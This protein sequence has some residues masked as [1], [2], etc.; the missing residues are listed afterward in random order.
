MDKNKKNIQPKTTKVFGWIK[1]KSVHKNILDKNVL[2]F[3][4]FI[5]YFIQINNDSLTTV[6]L[7]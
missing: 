2:I 1:L 7:K 5:V 4:E 6:G 3:Y